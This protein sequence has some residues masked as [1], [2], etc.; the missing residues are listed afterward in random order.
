M[1]VDSLPLT[2]WD[3]IHLA[4]GIIMRLTLNNSISGETRNSRSRPFPGM[5]ASDS[6]SQIT[7][8]DIFIVVPFLN[9]GNDLFIPFPF[10]KFGNVFFYFPSYSQVVGMVLHSLPVPECWERLFSIPFPFP[11]FRNR[12]IHSCSCPRTTT[13]RSRSPLF[14]ILELYI[15]F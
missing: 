6:R 8:M 5:K 9:F 3:G 1:R 4:I 12:I 11:N 7:G 15:Q 14:N 13:I 2:L 10:P